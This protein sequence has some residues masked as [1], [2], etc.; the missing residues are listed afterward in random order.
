[1]KKRSIMFF[2]WLTLGVFAVLVTACTTIEIRI[3]KPPTPDIEAVS[4]LANLMLEGT[5][6]AQ[7]LAERGVTPE[8]THSIP[9]TGQITGKVC[10]PGTTTPSLIT[11]FQNITTNEIVEMNID[12]YQDEYSLEL[13]PGEYYVYAWV[14]QYLVGGLYS[15]KVICGDQQECNDHTP[16]IVSLE[17]GTIVEEI[18]LCDWGLPLESLPIPQGTQLPGALVPGPFRE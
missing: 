14:P 10:Y 15:Q 5:Q 8:P 3:E 6:Y 13:V 7:I 11:Y 17:A 16:V 18:D 1:M 2:R 9:V 4:T 12:E